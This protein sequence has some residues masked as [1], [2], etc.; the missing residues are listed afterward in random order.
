MNTLCPHCSAINQWQDAQTLGGRV[1]CQQ[2]KETFELPRLRQ[3]GTS[4][5]PFKESLAS[6]DDNVPTMDPAL[7][8]FLQRTVGDSDISERSEQTDRQNT[9]SSPLKNSA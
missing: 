7:D 1:K 3:T 9:A 4:S 6:F 2:C 8:L 5:Q